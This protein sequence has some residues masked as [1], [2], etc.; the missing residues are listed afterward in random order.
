MAD[1][2]PDWL[3]GEDQAAS[4]PPLVS[5][6]PAVPSPFAMEA[7]TRDTNAGASMLQ[8]SGAA[9]FKDSPSPPTTQPV[10]E[11]DLPRIILIMRLANMGVVAALITFAV[12]NMVGIP[13]SPALWV[14]SIYAT[15]GGLLVCCLET[16]LRFLRVWIAINFGFLFSPFFRFFYYL[17]LASITW[18]YG[19]FFGLIVSI[20]LVVVAIFNTYVLFRYPSYR[21]VRER[22]AEEEDKKI[23]AKI[24][25]EVRKQAIKSLSQPGNPF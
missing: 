2:S 24:S 7:Q 19:S 13:S 6:A 14:L 15:C 25:G 3:T 16:Q 11:T 1:E 22:I 20:A 9:T 12:L 8:S 23:E 21:A 18:S 17:L 5:N 10:D 4:A